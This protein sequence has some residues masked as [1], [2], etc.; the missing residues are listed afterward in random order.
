MLEEEKHRSQAFEVDVVLTIPE[1]QHDG[2]THTV[3]Y[4]QVIDTVCQLNQSHHFQLIEA[5]AHAIAQAVLQRFNGVQNVTVSVT[6][7]PAFPVG[8]HLDGVRVEVQAQRETP[9]TPTSA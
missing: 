4:R 3:D 7:H 1:V 5:F 2:L 8:V 6:K 9:S